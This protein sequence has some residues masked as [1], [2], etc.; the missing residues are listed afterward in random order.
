MINQNTF[1]LGARTV[2]KS[3]GFV[4]GCHA[5]DEPVNAGWHLLPHSLPK[6]GFM[7]IFHGLGVHLEANPIVLQ[8]ASVDINERQ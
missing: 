2:C 1:I 4:T 7:N 6:S 3:F 8:P 5:P